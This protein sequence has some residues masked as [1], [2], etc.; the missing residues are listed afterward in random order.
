MTDL[1]VQELIP[2]EVITQELILSEFIALERIRLHICFINMNQP[3]SISVIIKDNVGTQ[4]ADC[5][6][7]FNEILA[8]D[9]ENNLGGAL[10]SNSIQW[11][12]MLSFI[13]TNLNLEAGTYTLEV[14]GQYTFDQER[15]FYVGIVKDHDNIPY[16]ISESIDLDELYKLP[17]TYKLYSW[18]PIRD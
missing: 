11:H 2:G 5:T 9:T 6:Y 14:S 18:Q 4:I 13:Y 1:L 8:L 12:G 15:T 3:G 7:S 10:T 17:I 16:A